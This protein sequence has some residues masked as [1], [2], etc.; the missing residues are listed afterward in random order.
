MSKRALERDSS[1]HKPKLLSCLFLRD[2]LCSFRKTSGYG[3]MNRCMQC[4]YYETFLREM[5]AEDAKIMDEID[6]MRRFKP[7][8]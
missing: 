3:V 5:D 8:G 4:R 6:R 2:V 7:L 1:G